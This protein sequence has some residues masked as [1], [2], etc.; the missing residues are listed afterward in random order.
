[1]PP[2]NDFGVIWKPGPGARSRHL[3]RRS[4]NFRFPQERIEAAVAF[5]WASFLSFDSDQ[6][7]QKYHEIINYPSANLGSNSQR[8]EGFGALRAPAAELRAALLLVLY[9]KCTCQCPLDVGNAARVAARP[10]F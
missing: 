5:D 10:A 4:H 1:M 7:R 3:S 6:K 9:I 2:S 8:Q